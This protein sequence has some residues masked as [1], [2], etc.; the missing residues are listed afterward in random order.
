MGTRATGR[1]ALVQKR[2]ARWLGAL[3]SGCALAAGCN[4]GG[5]LLR[6]TGLGP[7][8]TGPAEDAFA[9]A[10][11]LL[12]RIGYVLS[13]LA[14]GAAAGHYGW[15]PSVAFTGLFPLVA[16]A[17]I[18]AELPETANRELEDTAELMH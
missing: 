7:R 1:S 10:N 6:D 9:W 2:R 13:P 12:G 4:G 18:L 17:M 8:D 14:V 5:S 16:I 3:A 15:G 11:N